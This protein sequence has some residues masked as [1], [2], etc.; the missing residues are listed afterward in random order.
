VL[1]AT[2]S[3]IRGRPGT[4][5]T[6]E[7]VDE[8]VGRLL[9]HIG[10][11]ALV[12]V[13][14]D[15][16]ATSEALAE[17][18]TE[19]ILARG[20]D[21][22]HL[23]IVSTPGARVAALA[24]GAR[25]V[26]MVTGSHLAEDL[27]GLKLAGPPRM[28]P[29]DVR[30]LSDALPRGS[31]RGRR[32]SEPGAAELH[33]E[34]VCA[35]VDVEGIR[36]AGLAVVLRGGAGDGAAA[37]LE[38]LGCARVVGRGADVTLRLDADADRLQ[39]ADAHGEAID[40]EATLALAVSRREPALVV[41]SSD[42]SRM[43]DAIQASRGG[44]VTV[45]PPGELHL[46]RAL[47]QGKTDALAGEGNGGVIVPA[48]GPGRDGLAVGAIVLELLARTEAPLSQLVA[49]LPR[50]SRARSTLPCEDSAS[51]ATA[52]GRAA[53]VLGLEAPQDPEVGLIVER[54][55]SWGLVRRSATEPVLKLTT[56]AP[57]PRAA[58]TLHEEL[59]AALA[60]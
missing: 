35:A 15:E 10:L 52:L 43:V 20:A 21:A 11:P 60:P 38:R 18:V 22:L 16:R 40:S 42:T 37:A 57:K 34:A 23:G 33:A 17:T 28:G 32:Q 24:R 51:A 19:A 46:L 56:E 29:I 44:R 14:R 30:E 8:S 31:Q 59:L 54:G 55:D 58:S 36:S 5:L 2:H 26:V 48:V 50:L 39:L 7:V 53:Q 1:I 6:D 13:A 27:N 45:V 47:P 49:A 25:G 9:A 12:A 3:G 41:R 4:E